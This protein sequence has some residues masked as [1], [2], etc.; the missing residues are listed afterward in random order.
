MF[1]F[2]LIAVLCA[3]ASALKLPT[4]TTR[5]AIA[6]AAAAA[7]LAFAAAAFADGDNKYLGVGKAG[8]G[9]GS[10]DVHGEAGSVHI[11]RPGALVDAAGSAAPTGD[12]MALGTAGGAADHPGPP[13]SENKAPDAAMAR[14][15]K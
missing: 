11:G 9:A 15:M 4:T 1:R 2:L 10:I 7:P 5:R 14:L 12:R 3:F 6:Q 8:A 13:G